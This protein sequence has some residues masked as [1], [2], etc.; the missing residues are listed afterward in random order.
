MFTK[1]KSWLLYLAS[2]ALVASGAFLV[3]LSFRYP[4]E[5]F[6]KESLL[7]LG[8][9]LVIA[10]LLALTVDRFVKQRLVKEVA[11]DTAR[12]VVG[13]ELPE[14][15]R[16]RIQD[17]LRT[18]LVRTNY[19]ATYRLRT[20][21]QGIELEVETSWNIENYSS[22]PQPYTQE[23]I[24]ERHE[25]ATSLSIQ[26]KSSDGNYNYDLKGV[27][28]RL[29]ED[30]NTIRVKGDQMMIQPRSSGVVY[31]VLTRFVICPKDNATPNVFG[32][33]TFGATILTEVPPGYSITL[34][35]MVEDGKQIGG[36]WRF[37]KLFMP[38]E[39]IWI[40]WQR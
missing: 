10:G 5:P 36:K 38:G 19:L 4:F 27:T 23:V 20:T 14:E 8:H 1:D 24:L 25:R 39:H 11:R 21:E 29:A 28:L 40:R 31:D 26:G 22:V 2:I 37:N 34:R 6:N 16:Q 30:E 7:A 35:S 32:A 12:F 18:A 13:Y 9:A 33:P 3:W 17:L 15:L